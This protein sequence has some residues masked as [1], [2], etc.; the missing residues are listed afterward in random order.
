[1]LDHPTAPTAGTR[2][3]PPWLQL[4][5]ATWIVIVAI[6]VVLFIKL[7]PEY[8]DYLHGFPFSQLSWVGI[9]PDAIRTGLVS[10]AL[11]PDLYV[12][13]NL[14]VVIT[15]TGILLVSAVVIANRKWD[16]WLGLLLSM[17]YACYALG[18][19]FIY[20]FGVFLLPQSLISFLARFI[21]LF[22][23]VF[24]YNLLFYLFPDGRFIP[25]WTR[26]VAILSILWGL[27]LTISPSIFSMFS[28]TIGPLPLGMALIIAIF[29]SAIVSQIYRYVRVSDPM[30]RLQTKWVMFGFSTAII[31]NVA[32][33]LPRLFLPV[34]SQPG[35]ILVVY[36]FSALTLSALASLFGISS[37]GIAILRYRLWDIDIIIRRTLVYGGLTATLAL[38]YL[39]SVILLQSLFT[40][41][42]GQQSAVAVVISTL[43]IAAL[44]NPLRKRIQNDIDRRFFRRKYDA[45]KIVAD[46]SASLREQV[47]LDELC[48]RLLVV[49]EETLQPD[50]VLLW[51]RPS[52]RSENVHLPSNVKR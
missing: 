14:I 37:F 2:L 11:Y 4:A 3:K 44:F 27:Y 41:I 51:L 9:N 20:S 17:S 23:G 49:V 34:L 40:A 19:I 33:Y 16:D 15:H 29:S 36:E 7:M 38:V 25:R 5:R 22:C 30:Q 1:M 13:Y 32:V 48:D 24:V 12:V 45:E 10:M 52:G 35:P 6:G 18:Y 21:F 28:T 50:S 26:W 47:D 39:T 31:I 43:V 42:S 8:L 46:F